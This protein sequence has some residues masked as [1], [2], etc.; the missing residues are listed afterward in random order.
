MHFELY[1][2]K[3][4]NTYNLW[5][6]LTPLKDILHVLFESLYSSFKY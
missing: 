3:F 2:L 4:S 6:R 5:E 1:K